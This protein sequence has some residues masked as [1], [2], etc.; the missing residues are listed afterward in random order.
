[1][2]KASVVLS[3]TSKTTKFCPIDFTVFNKC[4]LIFQQ[5][6]DELIWTAKTNKIKAQKL[7]QVIRSEEVTWGSL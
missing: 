4:Y 6:L 3:K 1:M 5:P 7:A 2:C